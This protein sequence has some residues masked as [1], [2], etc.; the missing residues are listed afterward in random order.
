M[1][2][3]SRWN[4]TRSGIN[5]FTHA[6]ASLHLRSRSIGAKLATYVMLL[7]RLPLLGVLFALLAAVDTMASMIPVALLRRWWRLA[8][9]R[10]LSRGVLFILG[11]HSIPTITAAP[12]QLRIKPSKSHPPA[13]IR[14]G[15]VIVTNRCSYIDIL[16]WS[17]LYAPAFCLTSQA[18][19]LRLV[20]LMQALRASFDAAPTSLG[21]SGSSSTHSTEEVITRC[22]RHHLG[23]L[24]L[25]PECAPSNNKSVLMFGAVADEVSRVVSEISRG[26]GD[27]VRLRVPITHVAALHYPQRTGEFCPCYVAGDA[28]THVQAVA[29]ECSNSVEVH[30][31]AQGHSPQPADFYALEA[32]H[33]S[34]SSAVG[35]V[36]GGNA[37]RSTAADANDDTQAPET[38]SAAARSALIQLV[39]LRASARGVALGASD[40]LDY[41]AFFHSVAATTNKSVTA[42]ALHALKKTA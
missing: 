33:A 35:T 42:S 12:M 26:R 32:A 18:G 41:C 19:G 16:V 37:T 40:F 10:P 36:V 14:S 25:Q 9:E 8:C 11:F 39:P 22:A 34:T 27:R 24:L 17:S 28:R 7:L 29:S 1:E 23:P 31:C 30:M 15:D 5:P 38:W 21:G 3:F 4:D 13:E 20:S 6:D 2:K